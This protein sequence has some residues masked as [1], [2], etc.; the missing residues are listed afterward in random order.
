MLK[1]SKATFASNVVFKLSIISLGVDQHSGPEV[2]PR[3]ARRGTAS[4]ESS[5]G[6]KGEPR[7]TGLRGQVHG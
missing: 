1:R 5:Y 2:G 4:R 7:G 3:D 6:S